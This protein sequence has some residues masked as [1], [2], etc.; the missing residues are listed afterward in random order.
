MASNKQGMTAV[1]G[2]L[3][4]FVALSMILAV[5][6][7]LSYRDLKEAQG[8]HADTET[9]LQTETKA[10]R[11]R[12]AD[13]QVLKDKTGYKLPNVGAADSAAG[14]GSVSGQMAADITKFA[15]GDLGQG[16]MRE[17]LERMSAANAQLTAERDA[18][19]AEKATL[20]G[21]IASLQEEYGASVSANEKAREDAEKDRD[22]AQR[23]KEETI[24]E[25]DKQIAGLEERARATQLELA[26][27][28]DTNIRIV[29]DLKQ[30]VQN[31][32]NINTS[33]REKQEQEQDMSFD[34]PDG[35]VEWVDH[36]S[37]LVWINLGEADALKKRTSFSVYTKGNYGVGRRDKRDIKGSIEVTRIIGPHQAEARII[38]DTFADPIAPGDPIYTPLWGSGKQ[39]HFALIGLMDLDRDGK[40][41]RAR[42]HEIIESAGAVIDS[43]VNDQGIRVPENSRLSVHTKFLIVGEIPD[44]SKAKP[45]EAKAFEAIGIQHGEMMREAREQGIKVVNLSDFLDYIG[46]Q[47]KR[48]LWQPGEESIYNLKKGARSTATAPS[49]APPATST[50]RTSG[51]YSSGRRLVPQDSD[52]STSK[53]FKKSN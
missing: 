6:A 5:V 45:D 30:Q 8:R 35:L 21:R 33:L 42:L 2:S 25:K 41:D 31:L 23:N 47:P 7:Y 37:R 40:S 10:H 4:F 22:T 53:T 34:Q 18:L 9:K 17:T 44:P 24:A 26:Q 11:D 38:G 16:T 50:G 15:P 29:A 36:N 39:E 51:L 52:G 12:D 28:K 48:R 32:T 27:E 14:D 43:E 20:Q 3:I 49:I 13:I 1:H 19:N 46:Y